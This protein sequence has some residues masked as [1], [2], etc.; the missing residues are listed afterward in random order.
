MLRALGN[1][2]FGRFRGGTGGAEPHIV[3][4]GLSAMI[5]GGD[6]TGSPRCFE[7]LRGG[8]S[9]DRASCVDHHARAPSCRSGD[10]GTTDWLYATIWY[11]AACASAHMDFSRGYR[12]HC[13]SSRA[14]DTSARSALIE[15]LH[16]WLRRAGRTL[17]SRHVAYT[18]SRARPSG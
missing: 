12:I 14:P 9:A 2:R 3:T 8:A 4:V 7:R 16:P 5:T 6:P 17:L 1:P 15:S 13:G 10:S 18:I 11:C